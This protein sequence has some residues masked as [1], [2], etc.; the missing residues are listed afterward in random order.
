MGCCYSSQE[1]RHSRV[2]GN[3]GKLVLKAFAYLCRTKHV[4]CLDSRLRGNDSVGFSG[5]MVQIVKIG[6]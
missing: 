2:G 6:G 4:V 5:D 1:I 3:L